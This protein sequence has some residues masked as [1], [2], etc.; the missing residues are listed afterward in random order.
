LTAG[1]LSRINRRSRDFNLKMQ[2]RTIR[3]VDLPKGKPAVAPATSA[4]V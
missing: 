1:I 3:L 2:R 4:D